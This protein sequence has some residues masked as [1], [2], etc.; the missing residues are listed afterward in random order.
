MSG[1]QSV[2][3][4]ASQLSAPGALHVMVGVI[5]S[6]Q[7][8]ILVARRPLEKRYGGFWEFP[9]GK[10]ERGETPED[11][12]ARELEEEL[13]L[14]IKAAHP[15]MNFLDP[16][17]DRPIRLDVWRITEYTGRFCSASMRAHGVGKGSGKGAESVDLLG[18]EGQ[19]LQWA[20]SDCLSQLTFPPANR[21][22]L[23]RLGLGRYYAI[24]GPAI[25]DTCDNSGDLLAVMQ[26]YV[27][28]FESL[29]PERDRAILQIRAHDLSD[30]RY[31]QLICDLA[32]LNFRDNL[33]FV[34]NRYK[35]FTDPSDIDSQL[36]CFDA[37]LRVRNDFGLHVPQSRLLTL[38]KALSDPDALNVFWRTIASHAG[39]VGASCH[40]L[41][42]L[43][44]ADALGLDYALLSPVIATTSHPGVEGIGWP[45]F[46]QMVSAVD[47]P[48]YALGGMDLD[49]LPT[50]LAHGAQGVAGI[51]A[52]VGESQYE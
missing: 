27:E 41:S 12:L 51:R 11:A 31:R 21:R 18:R 17:A 26:N 52:F 38:H 10:R 33:Q 46:E 28:H 5:E 34:T 1:K 6:P 48:V 43:R 24:T 35:H 16:F 8:E 37:G 47:V 15:F 4:D 36:N 14:Q 2:E 13:G 42:S 20:D 32:E 22:I 23:K 49:D 19:P 30:L 45:L 29:I 25:D 44:A 39:L 40:D 3:A 50:A 9:G 7:G